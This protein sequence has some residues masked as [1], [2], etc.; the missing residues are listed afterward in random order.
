MTVEHA[1]RANPPGSLVKTFNKGDLYTSIEM[2]L[3]NFATLGAPHFLRIHKSYAVNTNFVDSVNADS[4]FI[5]G[6]EL[7]IGRA[8]TMIFSGQCASASASPPLFRPGANTY[9]Q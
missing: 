9:W 5:C 4:V 1:G 8:F 6:I 7:P 3:N 2:C